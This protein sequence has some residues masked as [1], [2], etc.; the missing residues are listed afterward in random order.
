MKR[1]WNYEGKRIHWNNPPLLSS[2]T[3]DGDINEH[4]LR[5]IIRFTLPHVNGYYPIGTYDC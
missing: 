2:F 1:F 4:S 3:K 5:E